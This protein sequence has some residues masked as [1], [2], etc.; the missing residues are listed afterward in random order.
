M[1]LNPAAEKYFLDHIRLS[2]SNMEQDQGRTF[3]SSSVGLPGLNK[4]GADIQVA[5]EYCLRCLQRCAHSLHRNTVHGLRRKRKTGGPE[6]PFA[7]PTC[8]IGH[9][10]LS[11]SACARI[12]VAGLRVFQKLKLQLRT[13]RRSAELRTWYDLVRLR[14]DLRDAVQEYRGATRIAGVSPSL[15][16]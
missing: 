3:W 8:C 11:Q 14:K 12:D 15:R 5:G 2:S 7:L 6:T 13:E 16:K 4:F 1:V 9:A 10:H